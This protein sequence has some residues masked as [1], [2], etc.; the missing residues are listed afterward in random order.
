MATSRKG[1]LMVAVV[2]TLVILVTFL[3]YSSLEVHYSLVTRPQEVLYSIVN[4]QEPLHELIPLAL[5]GLKIKLLH[6]NRHLCEDD[7]IKVIVFVLSRPERNDLRSVIRE[8]YG[9]HEKFPTMKVTFA[10][11]QTTNATIN[12]DIVAEHAEHKDLIIGDYQEA[13]TNCSY[14]VFSAMYWVDQHCS[15]P[16]FT[17]KVDEDVLINTP[18]V[19][20]Y[21]GSRTEVKHT[22][23]ISNYPAHKVNGSFYCSHNGVKVLRDP[24]SK[25]YA[26]EEQYSEENYPAYCSGFM[27]MFDTAL[28]PILWRGTAAVK[29]LWIEDAFFPG[30]VR[31]KYN[32]DIPGHNMRQY[33]SMLSDV[34]PDN[35]RAEFKKLTKLK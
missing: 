29:F 6:V 19:L 20:K 13:Y 2:S 32:I 10:V 26:P 34:T 35:V 9:N 23:D 31:S 30:V 7:K 28:T 5:N 22:N 11:G 12:E 4:R 14:K 24:E 15:G 25:W 8:T 17:I 18:K 16:P 3:S 1:C 21:L 33:M 27:Y